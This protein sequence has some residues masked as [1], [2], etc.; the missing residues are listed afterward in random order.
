MS[1]LEAPRLLPDNFSNFSDLG[2]M[3]EP[4]GWP[5]SDQPRDFQPPVP[6]KLGDEKPLPIHNY[7]LI[8]PLLELKPEQCDQTPKYFSEAGQLLFRQ[9]QAEG[10][11]E[12]RIFETRFT[13]MDL[14]MNGLRHGGGVRTIKIARSRDRRRLLIAVSDCTNAETQRRAN[15]TIELPEDPQLHGYGLNIIDGYS[16]D[17]GY[18]NNEFDRAGQPISKTVWR[19]IDVAGSAA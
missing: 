10:V 3:Q 2:L 19:E 8:Q 14:A 1:I 4:N 6:G 11:D 17:G 9:L 16:V 12:P 13:F 7:E 15:P 18:Q 5:E